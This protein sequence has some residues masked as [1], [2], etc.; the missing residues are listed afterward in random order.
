MTEMHDDPLDDLPVELRRTLR[1][2]R[3][4]Y[5]EVAAPDAGP[6]VSAFMGVGLTNDKGDLSATAASNASE[7]A[8]TQVVG[9]PNW[10]T[11]P[12]RRRHRTITVIGTFVGTAVGKVALGTAI[13]AAGIG[14]GQL[15]GIVDLPGFP[16]R[17][18]SATQLEERPGRIGT[19]ADDRPGQKAPVPT[20][21]A[22]DSGHDLVTPGQQPSS[23]TTSEPRPAPAAAD[24]DRVDVDRDRPVRDEPAPADAID[25]DDGLEDAE[26]ETRAGDGR[27]GSDGDDESD[28]PELDDPP[29]PME[30]IRKLPDP[31]EDPAE[32]A[33]DEEG[34]DAAAEDDDDRWAAP[35]GQ[36]PELEEGSEE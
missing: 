14:A 26:G 9:L 13:A 29:D 11:R 17:G 24:S 1:E 34:G 15:T 27:D 23:T 25:I 31:D 10:R 7:P 33:N 19:V 32:D 30:D 3:R 12:T 18:G 21:A 2:L 36:P 35:E 4:T 8:E 6:V 28:H 5:G 20:V 16:G 22:V